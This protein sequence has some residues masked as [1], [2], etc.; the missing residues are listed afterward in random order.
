MG[1]HFAVGF[2]LLGKKSHEG[3]NVAKCLGKKGSILILE[4]FSGKTF[5]YSTLSKC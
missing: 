3:Q 5:K 2:N 1:E 4:I